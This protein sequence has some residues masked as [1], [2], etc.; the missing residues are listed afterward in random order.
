MQSCKQSD[1]LGHNLGDDVNTE[2][3][4]QRYVDEVVGERRLQ[5]FSMHGVVFARQFINGQFRRASP[6]Q[7]GQDARH[8]ADSGESAGPTRVQCIPTDLGLGSVEEHNGPIRE[9][10]GDRDHT[11]P[12]TSKLHRNRVR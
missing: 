8:L 7:P 10:N 11:S 3:V 1:D 12:V 6:Q 4:Q 2:A 5:L 9:R